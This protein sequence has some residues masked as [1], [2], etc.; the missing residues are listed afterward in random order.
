MVALLSGMPDFWQGYL[1]GSLLKAWNGGGGDTYK[2]YFVLCV[3]VCV[4]VCVHLAHSYAWTIVD[5]YVH[6]ALAFVKLQITFSISMYIMCVL[7]VQHF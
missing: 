6:Y 2:V 5:V 3:C 4:C 1:I 7:F